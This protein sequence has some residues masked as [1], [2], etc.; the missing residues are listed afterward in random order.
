MRN[1]IFILILCSSRVFACD[2]CNCYLGL[3]PHYKKNTF[4]IRYHHMYYN[5]THMS[6]EEL[7][8][9]DLSKG[10]FLEARTNIELHG[11]W[12]P[13]QKLQFTY[14]LPYLISNEYMRN[15][16]GDAEHIE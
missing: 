3:N 5:G 12:Y 11:Q 9:M 2:F 15:A 10:D 1:L 16:P 4:G 13:V 7:Q 8:E 6:N 14:S